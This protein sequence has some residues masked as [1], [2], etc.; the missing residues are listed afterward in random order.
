MKE[1]SKPTDYKVMIAAVLTLALI[2]SAFV[3][4][5]HQIARD[6]TEPIIH[7]VEYK[8]A[9]SPDEPQLFNASITDDGSVD[10]V[11]KV[12]YE[13]GGKS[14]P[15]VLNNGFFIYNY[16]NAEQEGTYQFRVIAFDKAGNAATYSGNF[17]VEYSME[18][19][20]VDW[21]VDS[22]FD[23]ALA[24][25]F[26][27][28][29]TDI[30]HTL[31]PN[32]QGK[33]GLMELLGTFDA[34]KSKFDKMVQNVMKDKNAW[35]DYYIPI[36]GYEPRNMSDFGNFIPRSIDNAYSNLVAGDKLLKDLNLRD[37]PLNDA[38][39]NFLLNLTAF[40]NASM[41]IA[42]AYTK[43]KIWRVT[44]ATQNQPNLLI[45]Y[46]IPE[47]RMWER[48]YLPAYADWLSHFFED[49]S[50]V[51]LK[52][53][54]GI[55][56]L[57]LQAARLCYAWCPY[58]T[59]EKTDDGNILAPY[60]LM[61]NLKY[62]PIE[63]EKLVNRIWALHNEWENIGESLSYKDD[64][65]EGVW[66]SPIT[67]IENLKQRLL[68]YGLFR[69]NMTDG[70]WYDW[71]E[72]NV[73]FVTTIGD[74]WYIPANTTLKM[75]RGILNVELFPQLHDEIRFIW[76]DPEMDNLSYL[77]SNARDLE[78]APDRPSL[79]CIVGLDRYLGGFLKYWPNSENI[80]R[81]CIGEIFKSGTFY[82][83]GI[84][85]INGFPHHLS[86]TSQKF[87]H[88]ETIV[89]GAVIYGSVAGGSIYRVDGYPERGE[90]GNAPHG[91]AS[92]T[93]SDHAFIILSPYGTFIRGKTNVLSSWSTEEAAE[94]DELHWVRRRTA[95]YDCVSLYQGL[96]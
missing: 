75:S 58:K 63:R 74:R 43:S 13:I 27:S 59:W 10:N 91:D 79:S 18:R 68:P 39:L 69:I 88:H 30:V 36:L 40:N 25:D 38:T 45:G 4:Y 89:D 44:N 83:K 66:D 16:T 84:I 7:S 34:D 22:N 85:V 6:R 56:A 17:R 82:D 41:S 11:E 37:I 24:S 23:K 93:Q 96:T 57:G 70:E 19:E 42:D 35:S 3:Y 32:G 5:F 2:G 78:W 92:Q 87:G 61:N 52:D 33:V 71:P 62:D 50:Y 94:K 54:R 12:S 53:W 28:K 47:N 67:Q 64:R 8:D 46:M 21:A 48:F 31:F 15:A 73:D 72:P 14:Y 55:K 90:Y 26:Y 9:I 86:R 29:Y 81:I 49:N 80:T 95:D 1:F 60:G 65:I 77:W 20:F 51:E 76:T